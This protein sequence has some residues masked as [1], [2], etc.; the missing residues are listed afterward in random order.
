MSERPQVKL[1][2]TQSQHQ[3]LFQHLFPGDGLEAMAVALCGRRNDAAWHCLSVQELAPIPYDECKVRLADRVTWSTE[4]LAPLLAKAAQRDLAVITVHSH[5]GGYP[6]FSETDDE[7]DKEILGSVFDWTDSQLPQASAVMLPDGT[8]F[9]RATFPDGD[10]QPL[11]S[12]LVAGDDLKFWTAARQVET[13]DFAQRHAQLFGRGTFNRLR[14]LS[15]AVV[16]C[17]GT[18]SPLIEQLARLGVGRLVL[19][20]PDRVEKKNLNRIL[21]ATSE[22]ARLGRYKVEVLARAIL[23]MGTGA[24]VEPI[25]ENLATPRAIRA[26]ATCDIVFGCMDGAE[27]R[28]LLNRLAAFYALPYFDIGVKLV[29]DGAG[30]IE[31]A[32]GAVHYIRPDGDALLDRGVYSLE[33]YRAESL[34]RTDPGAYAEQLKAGYIQRVDED[35]PA[36][37]SINMQMASVAINEFLARLHPYRY[38][39][40]ADSAV[41]R[42]SF[43]S[44]AEFREREVDARSRMF[45]RCVGKADVTPLLSMPGLS[46]VGDAK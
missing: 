26:V 43:I 45:S 30:G 3:A 33:Q 32:C 34:R 12:I 35:S 36:V 19:V 14:E 28:H 37:V 7:S 20:D 15:V 31:E 8:M 24:A 41:V 9:G 16:G 11:H 4:R 22:D 1:R 18:G 17:S 5:P 39:G 40:N 29:A 2:L 44:P 42:V 13:P 46:D 23:G 27:G 10:R 21:N 38:D 25:A 6:R